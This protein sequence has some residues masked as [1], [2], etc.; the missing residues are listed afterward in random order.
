MR[1][2]IDTGL[3]VFLVFVAISTMYPPDTALVMPPKE[4]VAPIVGDCDE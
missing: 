1:Q 4:F 2:V 3:I